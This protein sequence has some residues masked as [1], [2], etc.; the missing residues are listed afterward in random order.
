MQTLTKSQAW[1]D[2]CRYFDH[3]VDGIGAHID[4]VI[5][6]VV[7]GLNALGVNTEASC[8][9]HLD[10][11]DV[12]PW[13]RIGAPDTE[14]L[15]EEL[16]E[17]RQKVLNVSES[18]REQAFAIYSE[19][20]ARLKTLHMQEWDKVIDLLDRFYEQHTASCDCRLIVSDIL[21]S[22]QFFLQSQGAIRQDTRDVKLK[23]AKLKAYQQEMQAFAS[24][25]K[26]CFFGENDF[27]EAEYPVGQ[28]ADLLGMRHRTLTSHIERGNLV[29]KKKGRDY[30]ISHNELERF[31]NTPRKVG[32]PSRKSATIPTNFQE[33]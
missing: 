19:L 20:E 32:R 16:R 27:D 18:E 2:L 9:G 28:A 22:G 15:E 8:E 23:A 3:V 6:G 30:Y 4:P 13:I 14:A 5:M 7:V 21:G 31:K 25:L 33:A 17:A 29:A 24:F 11:G 1:D 10:H 12:H 26:R